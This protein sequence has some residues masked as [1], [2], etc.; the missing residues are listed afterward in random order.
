MI[1]YP[2]GAC[3]LGTCLKF[4]STPPPGP[5]IGGGKVLLYHGTADGL[6]PYGNTGG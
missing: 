4:V 3:N 1:R 2:G 5:G 6:I